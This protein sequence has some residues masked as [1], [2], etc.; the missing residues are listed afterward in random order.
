MPVFNLKII[1]VSKTFLSVN[2]PVLR[3][4]IGRSLKKRLRFKHLLKRDQKCAA[5]IPEED[6]SQNLDILQ[7]PLTAPT[8]DNDG[9][10]LS[11]MGGTEPIELDIGRPVHC[12]RN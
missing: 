3:F 5:E 2:Y 7:S 10:M 12:M 4:R 6:D 9:A 8:Y 11:S 1:E